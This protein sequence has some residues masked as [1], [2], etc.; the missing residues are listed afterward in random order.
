MKVLIVDDLA[1][2]RD[3]L[4]RSLERAGITVGEAV[5]GVEA[6]DFLLREPFDALVTDILMPQ[7][8][9]YRLCIEIRR[10]ARLRNLPIIVCTG[11][12][13]SEADAELAARHGADRFLF[14]STTSAVFV[15]TLTALVESEILRGAELAAVD[16]PLDLLEYNSHLVRKLAQTSRALLERNADLKCA[17]EQL[18]AVAVRNEKLRESERTTI[19]REIHDVLSQDLA[20]LKIDLIWLGKQATN[21]PDEGMRGAITGRI[22]EAIIQTDSAINSVLNIASEL[23]PVV[24]DSLGL[25]AAIEWQAGDFGR[26]FG[27]GVG[28]DVRQNK[29]LL[30]RE[31][32]TALFRILQE[33]LTNISRHSGASDIQVGFAEDSEC[34]VL[35]VADNGRGITPAEIGAPHSI[36]LVGMRERAQAFGGSWEITGAPSAGTTV[37]VWFPLVPLA[38][39]V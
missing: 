38:A 36:G 18:R 15:E 21:P 22:A 29:S 5:D 19:A 11:S 2:D 8:D 7:M 28:L 13:G 4:R 27:L 12:Y 34:A 25:A 37:R 6:I 14:K 30:G 35:T 31:S 24:L 3:V 26:R 33:C 32:S 39:S 23:R 16:D 9:G 17:N 1:S 10:N 20:C